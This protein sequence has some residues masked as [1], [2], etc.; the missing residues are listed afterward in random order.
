MK[1]M[2]RGSGLRA[3]PKLTYTENLT[4]SN[5]ILYSHKNLKKNSLNILEDL[6]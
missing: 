1:F 6:V 3:E 2:V 4:K 5:E